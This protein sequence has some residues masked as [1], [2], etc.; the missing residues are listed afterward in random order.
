MAATSA[1]P[2]TPRRSGRAKANEKAVASYF[3]AVA[4]RDADAM[5]GHWHP[6]GVEE[7]IPLGVVRGPDGVR[8]LFREL[9]RAVPDCQM[10]VEKMVVD[11]AGAAVE[12]R[13]RGTFDGGPFQGIEPTGRTLDLRGCDVIEVDEQGKLTRNVAHYDGAAFARQIGMLPSEDSGADRAMRAGFNTV[14]RLRAAVAQRTRG[15]TTT[16]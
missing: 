5:A 15:G 12:W 9:F 3:A 8:K 11:T 13:M 1:K 2:S 4:A 7:L 14:T 10:V 16:P 6:D